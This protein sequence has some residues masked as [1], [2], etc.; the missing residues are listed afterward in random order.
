[1]FRIK[2]VVQEEPNDAGLIQWKVVEVVPG[3]WQQGI[4]SNFSESRAPEQ[5]FV[6]SQ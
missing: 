5:A 4:G 3:A 2:G 6:A 1:M